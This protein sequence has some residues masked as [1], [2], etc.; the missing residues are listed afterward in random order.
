MKYLI[1]SDIHGSYH[2]LQ[3]VLANELYD[4]L[5]LL[6]D[7]LPHGPRNDLPLGY[8]PKKVMTMLNSLKDKII[9]VRGNCDAAVDD[10]VL[11][12]PILEMAVIVEEG[13]SYYLTHGH[14]Y[15]PDNLLAVNNSVVL[16][17]HTHISKIEK[18]GT[19][20]YINPGSISIPKDGYNSYATL[21]N[22]KLII[23][24]YRQ[25]PIKEI[26]IKKELYE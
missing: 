20:I 7:I 16:Y 21:E 4:K 9:C 10:M 12:F 25:N 6:G 13:I 24:D 19:N 14:Q 22:G 15:H 18:I 5:L 2:Y 11:A 26:D 23:K 8:E 17:G 1:I 3:D